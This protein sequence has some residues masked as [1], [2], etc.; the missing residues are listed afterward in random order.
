M[1]N[2]L[3]KGLLLTVAVALVTYGVEF[4]RENFWYGL[5]ALILGV[6]VFVGREILKAN[7]Y[8]VGAI[9]GKK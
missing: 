3:S 1:D 4:I 8:E 5:I 9:F 7:G 2:V 6:L